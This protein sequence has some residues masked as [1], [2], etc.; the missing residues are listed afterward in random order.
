[1]IR[2]RASSRNPA[3][4][5][6]LRRGGAR[7]ARRVDR[8]ARRAPA[9]R[10]A[11]HGPLPDRRRRA[12]LARGAAGAAPRSPGDR[13]RVRRRGDARSRADREHPARRTSTRSRRR[14]PISADR[15]H[16]HTQEALGRLVHK[17]RSH[18]ANLLRLLDLPEAC[19]QLLVR[20]DISMGHA[21]AI[22]GAEIPEALPRRSSPRP[23]GA[24]GRALARASASRAGRHRRASARN[25]AASTPTSR[26][27]SGSSATCSA[28]R[29]RSRTRP[30]GGTVALHYSSLDQLDMICQRLSGEPIFPRA[31]PASISCRFSLP[32]ALEQPSHRPCASHASRRA[33]GRRAGFILP[34]Q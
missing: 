15:E 1:M 30:D 27:S 10:G 25:A 33:C 3:S 12:A 20:G 18:V 22:A 28:S 31:A 29:S 14:R 32:L 24:P 4:R 34:E 9:D 8:A 5:A 11:A 7:R 17:S 23:L 2:S 21:R 6:A 16:G 26:R 13:P 19:A